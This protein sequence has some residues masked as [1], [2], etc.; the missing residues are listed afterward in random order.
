[1]EATCKLGE[2][3]CWSDG[4]CRCNCDCENKVLT[5]ANRVRAMSGARYEGATAITMKEIK[6]TIGRM[7]GHIIL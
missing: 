5:N 4:K 3:G 1:M 7:S 2:N 6:A